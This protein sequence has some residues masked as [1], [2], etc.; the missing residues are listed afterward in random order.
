[1]DILAVGSVAFDDIETPF[2]KREK[3]LG[4]SCSYFSLA[5]SH[6]SKVNLVAVVGEDFR[7]KHREVFSSANIDLEG[8]ETSPGKT[9]HWKGVYSD[10]LNERETLKTNLGVFEDFT[11]NIPESYRDSQT[12]FLANIDPE[13]QLS[14]LNQVE[15][16]AITACDTMNF[17]IDSKR[18]ALKKTVERIDILIINDSE[19]K[20]LAGESNIVKAAEKIL[21]WGPD[22][23]IV[24]RGEY[25][26]A[27]F[28]KD[29]FFGLPAYPLK[30]VRDPTGAGDSFA[31][32]FMGYVSQA[33][34]LND[35]TFK[36]AVA[37]GTVLSSFTVQDFSPESIK[38]ITVNEISQRYGD[39]RK[40]TGFGAFKK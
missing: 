12:V 23:V 17:W 26:A 40:F 5:A 31:G 1:M 7:R 3:V 6:F 20:Q 30:E 8:L 29:T 22:R 16:P 9:F 34:V 11:P 25:G 10:D 24:K 38:D 15:D 4:G 14:V 36:Q 18:E 2:G 33:G 37:A 19:V 27:G 13:L 32:G 35:E 28:G 21:E 39:L